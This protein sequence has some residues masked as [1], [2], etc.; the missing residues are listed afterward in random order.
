[1]RRS[2]SRT[3]I[4]SRK[5]Q[6]RIKLN[7]AM[8]IT[9]M[10]PDQ[11][12]RGRA[13]TW[14]TSEWKLCASLVSSLWKSRLICSIFNAKRKRSKFLVNFDGEYLKLLIRLQ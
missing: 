12:V 13:R 7:K 1:V 3:G 5:C 10:S 9:P 4:S 2:I 8:S 6:R 11:A 14:V